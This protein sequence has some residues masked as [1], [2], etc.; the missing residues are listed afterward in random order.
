MDEERNWSNESLEKCHAW[1]PRKGRRVCG[2]ERIDF[3]EIHKD[4]F[5][6]LIGNVDILR[7]EDTDERYVSLNRSFLRS[8]KVLANHEQSLKPLFVQYKSFVNRVRRMNDEPDTSDDMDCD[9]EFNF[10]IA[11]FGPFGDQHE[12][13]YNEEEKTCDF[14]RNAH[15]TCSR[16]EIYKFLVRHFGVPC[17]NVKLNDDFIDSV[18]AFKRNEKM[19]EFP[20]SEP[21]KFS[22]G[23]GMSLSLSRRG[24]IGNHNR[25]VFEAITALRK[26]KNALSYVKNPKFFEDSS[27]EYEDFEDE[28]VLR[29][30]VICTYY[31]NGKYMLVSNLILRA[32]AREGCNYINMRSGKKFFFRELD[33]IQA[34]MVYNR[35][36]DV[37][38][39]L[40]M[41]T[42]LIYRITCRHPYVAMKIYEHFIGMKI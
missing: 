4:Q 39:I 12:P 1:E 32:F 28:Y 13:R 14:R 41:K 33:G 2:K 30:N 16:S 24:D 29:E 35:G 15:H 37:V 40:V 23:S 19:T 3:G 9:V 18:E 22:K 21:L 7:H 31:G 38:Y 25:K 6:G 11:D 17:P 42:M 10:S 20:F 34:R 27:E 8:C 26:D 5:A 36:E